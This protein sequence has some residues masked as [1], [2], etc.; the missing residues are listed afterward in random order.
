MQEFLVC[1]SQASAEFVPKRAN[2]FLREKKEDPISWEVFFC[3]R[4]EGW[5][6]RM[7]TFH[8]V[9]FAEENLT[10]HWI[11]RE[12]GG[13]EMSGRNKE[14]EE[15]NKKKI[16]DKIFLFYFVSKLEERER[17][18]RVFSFLQLIVTRDYAWREFHWKREEE[19]EK[20]FVF[21]LSLSFLFVPQRL[22][23]H[24]RLATSFLFSSSSFLPQHII[25]GQGSRKCVL[26]TIVKFPFSSPTSHTID[27]WRSSSSFLWLT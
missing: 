25:R 5:Q 15:E 12:R 21:F 10:V 18:R 2:H 20:R 1:H 22:S 4:F 24:L 6:F 8:T 11:S 19:E 9:S 3:F 7:P 14:E 26:Y 17:D 16:K 23:L 13:G 27:R